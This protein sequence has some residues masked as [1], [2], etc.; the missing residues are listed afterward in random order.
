MRLRGCHARAVEA[1]EWPVREVAIELR[2]I[3]YRPR[4]RAGDR[5]GVLPWPEKGLRLR[6]RPEQGPPLRRR[7]NRS[8]L[9]PIGADT[10]RIA[11][12]RASATRYAARTAR[13][14]RWCWAE[15]LPI[16][17]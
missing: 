9:R 16:W 7:R 14:P 13:V 8:P 1:I 11:P 12:Q 5:R 10:R 15:A 17:R 2:A 4:G 3:A 6:R